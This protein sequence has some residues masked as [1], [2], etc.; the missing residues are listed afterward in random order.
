MHGNGS[1]FFNSHKIFDIPLIK[2]WALNYLLLDLVG[3]GLFQPIENCNTKH[4]PRQGL[5]MTLKISLGFL[6]NSFNYPEIV[7][8]GRSQSRVPA[9][10]RFP[11]IPPRSQTCE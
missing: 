9:K 2:K 5:K 8:L 3:F 10:P 6:D 7:M 11:F 4:L 1:F